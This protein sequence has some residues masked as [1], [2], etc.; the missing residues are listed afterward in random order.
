M[1]SL[2]VLTF[3]ARQY[4]QSVGFLD[5]EC[6]GACCQF[7]LGLGRLRWCILDWPDKISVADQD[8]LESTLECHN[9]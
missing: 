4:S 5:V 2:P 9:T 8:I 7:G 3:P 6:L 1:R